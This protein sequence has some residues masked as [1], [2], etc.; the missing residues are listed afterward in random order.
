MLQQLLGLTEEVL[1]DLTNVIDDVDHRICP[2]RQLLD[3]MPTGPQQA[4]WGLKLSEN[5]R[6]AQPRTSLKLSHLKT[7]KNDCAVEDSEAVYDLRP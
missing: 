1:T 6:T 3:L 4:L 5:L 7:T 2:L